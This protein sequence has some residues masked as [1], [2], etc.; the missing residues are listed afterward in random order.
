MKHKYLAWLVF[1]GITTSSCM[2]QG[3]HDPNEGAVLTSNGGGN[4]TFSWYVREDTFYYLKMS[5]SMMGPWHYFPYVMIG[6]SGG[7]SLTYVFNLLRIGPGATFVLSSGNGVGEFHFHS[8]LSQIFVRAEIQSATVLVDRDSDGILDFLE[9]LNGFSPDD[10]NDVLEDTDGDGMPDAY[11][12]FNYLNPN[13]VDGD[14]DRDGDSIPNREDARPNDSA[15]GR[16][17][18][19]IASPINGAILP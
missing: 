18:I 17:S 5:E 19:S 1:L 14:L 11:E 9:I 12:V 13:V 3:P 15:I 6:S 8:D 10:P 2:A 7:P 4:Y 16:L